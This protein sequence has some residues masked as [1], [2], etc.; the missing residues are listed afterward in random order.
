MSEQGKEI[1][2]KVMN[3]ANTLFG[4]LF[5]YNNKLLKLCNDKT[6]TPSFDEVFDFY[7][8]SHSM[9][10]IKNFYFNHIEGPGILLNARCILEGLALKKAY[11][12]GDID[13][14]NIE[15]LKRQDSLIEH[16][17]YKKFKELMEYVTIPEEKQKEYEEAVKFYKETLSS[18]SDEEIEKIMNSQIPF[19]CNPK[20]NYHQLIEEHLGKETADYYSMLSILIHPTSNEVNNVEFHTFIL[21]DTFN[22]I[23]NIYSFLPDGQIDLRQY[24]YF[25][26][27]SSKDAE[28]FRDSILEECTQ[29][30]QVQADFVKN[31]GNNYVSDTFHMVSMLI[32]EMMFDAVFGF[33]EQVKCKWKVMIELLA[34]FYE[35]Y[36]NQD[37][38][39]NTYRMLQ[40]HED[41]AIARAFH[42]DDDA[43]E[44]IDKA[45]KH[46][47]KKYPNGI[48]YDQFTHKYVSTLGYTVD[49]K[50]KVKNLTQLVNQLCNLF[51]DDKATGL[52]SKD[53]LKLNYVESQ[54]MSHANGYMWFANSGAWGDALSVFMNANQV[55]SFI[56]FYMSNIYK[57][58]YEQTKLYKDKKT[59]N[60]L[61]KAGTFIRDNTGRIRELLLKKDAN[62]YKYES[63]DLV[64]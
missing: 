62:L 22:W 13:E 60:V 58:G 15:L 3:E 35:V 8:T 18:Y 4:K 59:C 38:V 37:D 40:Y 48:D 23:K 12:D 31:F 7:L 63:N 46:Y 29:M 17:Q 27:F 25:Y 36:L 50:G 56:C 51:D 44:N 11:K 52:N 14:F 32:Q 57:D 54:M 21:L 26:I 9:T 24:A 41:V 49:E 1:F 42:Q 2:D 53:V 6:Y 34:S 55:I 20:M 61:K 43:K 28:K 33:N 47:Q 30:E 5:E 16:K 19:L 45:F 39:E 64:N 10:F